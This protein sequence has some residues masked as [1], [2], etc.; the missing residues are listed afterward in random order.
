MWWTNQRVIELKGE[1]RGF[2]KLLCMLFSGTKERTKGSPNRK[3]WI[4]LTIRRTL[5]WEDRVGSPVNPYWRWNKRQPN[6]VQKVD[7]WFHG[8]QMLKGSR[9]CYERLEILVIQ[10]LLSLSI[11]VSLGFLW[12]DLI[13]V[14]RKFLS[15]LNKYVRLQYRQRSLEIFLPFCINE[16]LVGNSYFF[17]ECG[18]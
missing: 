17:S 4:R 12:E 11:F 14:Y 9:V 10:G 5:K 3:L 18:L 7:N 1:E 2:S 15:F 6:V 13:S 16:F 8:L